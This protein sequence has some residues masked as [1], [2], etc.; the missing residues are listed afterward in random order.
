MQRRLFLQLPLVAEALLAEGHQDPKKGVKVDAGKDRYQEELL[1][2]GGTF[3]CKVSSEDTNGAFLL[4][5]TI[6]HEKGGPAL[7]L[8]HSQDEIFYVLK[9]EFLVK[10][11]DDSFPLKPGDTAFAP[12]KIP[13]AFAKTS[14]GEAQMLIMFQPAGSMEDYF[15]QV[16]EIGKEI[17]KN[18]Q[19]LL[20]EL[21]KTHGMELVGPPLPY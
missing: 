16:A 10:V 8:H 15:K 2:M 9:G 12:R 4:Y 17:P 11:G 13:H 3:D 19:Q 5:D 14:E 18:Q 20:K 6:R 21:F 1:I 7:H